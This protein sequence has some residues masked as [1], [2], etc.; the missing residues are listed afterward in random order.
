MN[1]AFITTQSINGSTVA[2][3][4]APLAMALAATHEVHIIVHGELPRETLA[5]HWHGA[6][7][8]PFTRTATGKDRLAGGRLL[9]RLLRNVWLA[10]A[11]LKKIAPDAVVISKPLPE[12]VLAV[13]LVRLFFKPKTTIL[14]VDDFELTA[15][16]LTSLTQRAAVH[17][18]ERLGASMA[19]TII[20][21][22]P[23]L[24]DHF[25]QL[26]QNSKKVVII[27]TGP[28]GI[29]ASSD[30]P[31]TGTPVITFIGS[32]SVSSGHR[33]DLLPEIVQT[34]VKIFPNVKLKLIGTG[35]DVALVRSR[36]K[37]LSLESHVTWHEGRF[38]HQDVAELLVDTNVLLDPID[39]SITN[40]AKSS[41][42]VMLALAYG[43]PVVTSNV[44]IRSILLPASFHAR[45]F[46]KPAHAADYAQ[47]IIAYLK[48]PLSLEEQAQLRLKSHEYS[49]P[50][51][52]RQY[53][54]YLKV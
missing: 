31:D 23:F 46:A 44:G 6:G 17:A 30:Q 14:D 48:N 1:I 27:P 19:D 35:D 47:K 18:G 38:Y 49:W 12:N 45:S 28:I 52:A 51:L 5:I 39:V 32:L 24:S 16:K 42:R 4:I 33:V 34:V 8:D 53:E 25:K 21:A 29:P 37:E 50:V 10:A 9:A 15:N 40:R 11:A 7:Q 2:G 20:T 13:W 54:E 41:Y 26:T 22:T 43:L 36:F 3:R